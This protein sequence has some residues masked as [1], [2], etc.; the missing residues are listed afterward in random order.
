MKVIFSSPAYDVVLEDGGVLHAE[1]KGKMVPHFRVKTPELKAR[2]PAIKKGYVFNVVHLRNFVNAYLCRE[3]L[4]KAD[5]DFRREDGD[6]LEAFLLTGPPG[7]GKSSFI[8]QVA[9]RIGM[10]LF[11]VN[12]D[13]Q[14]GFNEMLA[15]QSLVA[16]TTLVNYGI[17]VKAMRAGVPLLINEPNAL[18]AEQQLAILSIIENGTYT[19]PFTGEEIVAARGF[20][21]VA[22]MNPSRDM[23][24]AIV[25]HGTKALAPA[26]DRRFTEKWSFDYLDPKLEAKAITTAVSA[27]SNGVATTLV[28]IANK[29]RHAG[30]GVV[31]STPQLINLSRKMAFA[32]A[33]GGGLQKSICSDVFMRTIA[34][35]WPSATAGAAQQII[36]DVWKSA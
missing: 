1:F 34:N 32:A 21:V 13:G 14:E 28:E 15:T 30:F 35:T 3:Y 19:V 10:P 8:A 24:S 7:S 25:N 31:V 22:T 33:S 29:I 20:C 17:A 27:I 26:F 18:K 12:P 6:D 2:V 36:Q 9:A 11:A 4:P 5:F 23:D 16:G